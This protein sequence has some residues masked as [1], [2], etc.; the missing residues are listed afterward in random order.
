[1]PR[2]M[3]V[4][5]KD[6]S[7]DAGV[8]IKT[9]SRV[10]NKEKNVSE[11]TKA[12]VIKS[13]QKLGFKPN[14]S[15]QS[16][17]SKRSHMIALLYNNPN[18][19]YLADIQGGILRLCKETGYNLV[20]QECDYTNVN[21]GLEIT[22]FIDDFSIDGLIVTPPLSDMNEFLE[23]LNQTQTEYSI[24]AP[25][26]T[27]KVKSYVSSNDYEA[28][29][30][31]TNK[32]IN[33]GHLNIGFIKGHHKH[34][35]SHLRFNGFTEALKDRGMSLNSEWVKE[36]NFSFDSGFSAGLE[37]LKSHN[38][39]SV[40]FA[41]NDYMAAGVMKAAQM[42]GINIPLDLSLVG[43]D[44]SPLA[45]QLWP[46]L[47]TIRQPVEDMAY[48]AARLLLGNIDGLSEEMDSKE[49]ISELILRESLINLID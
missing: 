17:R 9:V 49:F 21:L 32:I 26:N 41:S 43:F 38:K 18:K 16:L 47:T 25:S 5:I 1:M 3:S 45:A 31:M 14:K 37:L 4:T 15:A 13:I 34:S 2:Q 23:H 48:H 39:P 24:I 46:S 27:R 12:I 10:I 30:A 42:N 40:I 44:D 7:N 19:H 29:Y 22:E 20:L 35:A 6:V 36:G 11:K 33:K 28:S 8:S